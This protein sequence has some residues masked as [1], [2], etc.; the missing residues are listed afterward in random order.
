MLSFLVEHGTLNVFTVLDIFTQIPLLLNILE[1]M[2]DFWP[3][4]IFLRECIVFPKVLV[5]EL[6]YRSWAIDSSSRVTVPV[7]NAT[8]AGTFLVNLALET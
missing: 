7:P 2:S 6:V 8:G 4:G 3:A 5:E 1:I